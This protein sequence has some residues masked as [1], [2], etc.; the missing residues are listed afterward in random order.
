MKSQKFGDFSDPLPHLPF[1][2]RPS[3]VVS[4]ECKPPSS[5]LCDFIYEQALR[6]C[7]VVCTHGC[8]NVYFL[9]LLYTFSFVFQFQFLDHS[10]VL[11][12]LLM[13]PLE[14]PRFQ[15]R[16]CHYCFIFQTAHYCFILQLPSLLFFQFFNCL[17]Y[18]FIFLNCLI[19]SSFFSII[20]FLFHFCNRPKNFRR[21]WGL[22]PSL[23]SGSQR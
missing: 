7:F 19:F 23:L 14:S 1:L 21:W 22:N 15:G 8:E 17:L 12:I 18:C 4:Q 9:W 10:I 6:T 3:C 2:P 11:P 20:P 5:Q 16:C 13:V